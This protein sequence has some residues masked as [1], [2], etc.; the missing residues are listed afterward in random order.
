M[1]TDVHSTRSREIEQELGTE[2]TQEDENF[3]MA[4]KREPKEG[5]STRLWLLQN[6]NKVNKVKIMITHVHI[7]AQ[8][9]PFSKCRLFFISALYYLSKGIL[10]YL[11]VEI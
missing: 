1:E 8:M 7:P 9:I 4:I 3:Y 6:A 5:K 2:D 10:V 11:V